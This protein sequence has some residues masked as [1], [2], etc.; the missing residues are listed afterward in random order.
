MDHHATD[1]QAV[2]RGNGGSVAPPT[3]AVLLRNLRG[4]QRWTLKEMSLKSGIPVST[5]SKIEHGRLTLSY[6]KVCAVSQ[7]LGLSMAELLAQADKGAGPSV[8]GRRSLG[9][10]D[11]A[12]HVESPD[13]DYYY[14][15][16]EL[17]RKRMIPVITRLRAT[18]SETGPFVR[19]PGEKFIY[20]L[21]G[22]IAVHTEFYDPAMLGPGQAMYIDSSMG[23]CLAAAGC[24]EAMVLNVMAGSDEH[25]LRPLMVRPGGAA[26]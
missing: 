12:A 11:R 7:R 23:H 3:L 19:C 26:G 25:L 1:V 5:L 2:G 16:S 4:R 6:D 14:L 13:R 9:D 22:R 8:T 24:D 17:R 21:S 20:V 10:L 18:T 15:C